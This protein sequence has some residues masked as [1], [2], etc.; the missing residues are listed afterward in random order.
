MATGRAARSPTLNDELLAKT[1]DPELRIGLLQY[2]IDTIAM[3]FYEIAILADFERHAHGLVEA[4]EPV[5]AEALQALYLDAYRSVCGDVMDDPELV[6]NAWATW[7]HLFFDR[8][9]YAFQYATSLAAATALHAQVAT[10][11]KRE[12]AAAVE[13]YLELLSAGGS[14]HPVELLR[15]AGVD[16]TDP[17]SLRALVDQ[18]DELVDQL[19]RELTR[20]GTLDR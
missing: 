12:R 1:K 2:R 19:E 7:V 14:D 8:P 17:A 6:G 11:P 13:R 15:R 10:G 3:A 18:M 9:F 5:T 20:Q 16:L 4:G